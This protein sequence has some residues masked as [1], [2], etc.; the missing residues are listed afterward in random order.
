MCFWRRRLLQQLW[1]AIHHGRTLFGHRCSDVA[2]FFQAADRDGSGAITRRELSA[3]MV[4]LDLGLSP[5]QLDRMLSTID[6]QDE[7]K[8][9]LISHAEFARWLHG[10][11]GADADVSAAPVC[12]L[13]RTSSDP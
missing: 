3:A 13:A 5:Q 8:D 10:R 2:S 6:G 9:G 11:L 12:C 4:R 1:D 7:A